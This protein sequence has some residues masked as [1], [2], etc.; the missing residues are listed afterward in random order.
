[1]FPFSY[2]R[3][4]I[5]YKF[6]VPIIAALVSSYFL[7][8]GYAVCSFQRDTKEI[9]SNLLQNTVHEKINQFNN[10][11]RQLNQRTDSFLYSPVVQNY[12]L[13]PQSTQDLL[14][15][16]I[17]RTVLSEDRFPSS[18]YLE[19]NYDR[20]YTNNTI[21][22]S[23]K[24]QYLAK[25][26]CLFSQALKNHGKMVFGYFPDSPATF[27]MA[28][29]VYQ[30]DIRNPN[31][32]IGFFICDISTS[33]FFNIFGYHRDQ[34]AI[35]YILTDTENQVI[36]N[37]SPFTNEEF[38]QLSSSQ[39]F[40]CQSGD[41]LMYK[42]ATHYPELKIYVMLN[43]AMLFENTYHSFSIQLFIILLS[44]ALIIVIILLTARKIEKQFSSFIQK[45]AET[46][47][48]DS[49]AYIT[50][51]SED[52]FA[53]LASVYNAMLKRI[54]TLIQ[55]VYEQELL[56]TT[57][58]IKSLQAQINPHFL[59][60]TLVSISS[61]IDLNHP[62][63]AKKALSCLAHVMRASIKGK[64]ILTLREDL[65][66]IQDYLFIQK[67]RFRDKILFLVEIPDELLDCCIPKLCIQPLIENSIIHGT[68]P[69]LEK[70]MIAILGEKQENSIQIS[71]RDNGVA[72]P[73][74]IRDRI[75]HYDDSDH[76]EDENSHQSIGLINIQKRIRLLYGSPYGLK[77]TSGTKSGNTV[78]I[79]L[80]R[81]NGSD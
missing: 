71:V 34:D 11:L 18:I 28:R 5:K 63:D 45:I 80:P 31:S 29:T 39:T 6:L 27:T 47:Q 12:L 72:I 43:E 77:I 4:S 38:S 54:H 41:L 62:E 49:H 17:N 58:E 66:F 30:L 25:K 70:G 57:A 53:Q 59:Y 3:M 48:I 13:D 23:T 20:F 67:L 19:D 69:L 60:N 46:N 76:S 21:Y 75:N 14:G 35:S 65:S 1:M 61:L 50:V 64:E 68:A 32:C 9:M 22:F 78:T 73:P 24:N 42:Y 44:M 16:E 15:E 51:S 79:L 7:L 74:N 40:P 37:S 55:T 10:Y 8:F 26:E 36:A 56:K 81:K 2:K 52:E 33:S